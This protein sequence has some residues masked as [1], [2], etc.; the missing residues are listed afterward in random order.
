MTNAN[1]LLNAI[2]VLDRMIGLESTATRKGAM[3]TRK[4]ELVAQLEALNA[5]EVEV[6]SSA[7]SSLVTTPY[8]LR[9]EAELSHRL[10]LITIHISDLKDIIALNA[11]LRM[12][13]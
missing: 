7:L 11:R 5:D 4:A 10:D 9:D 8:V 12:V 13:A 2:E 1:T 3:L 6:I